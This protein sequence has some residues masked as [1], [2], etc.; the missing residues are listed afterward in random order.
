ME[1]DH[2]N[3]VIAPGNNMITAPGT[4]K[5][6]QQVELVPYTKMT[7]FQFVPELSVKRADTHGAHPKMGIYRMQS[8]PRGIFFFV[9][10]I[11]FDKKPRH[12]ADMDRENLVTL[13]RELGFTNYYYEDLT[14][15]QCI[16]LLKQLIA[17][18]D[19]TQ[20]DS[21]VCCIQTHGDLVENKTQMEFVDGAFASTEEITEMFSNNRCPSL[22]GK[23]KLFFFPFCRGKF[24]DNGTTIDVDGGNQ[25][26]PLLGPRKVPTLCDVL[27]CYGTMPGYKAHRITDSGTWYV[28]GICKIFAEHAC[29]THV[30]NLLKKVSEYIIK[31][32]DSG[33]MQVASFENLGFN[34]LLYFNP[35]QAPVAPITTD[36]LTSG[37]SITM[38]SRCSGSW[39]SEPARN[40]SRGFIGVWSR[41]ARGFLGLF[42]RL[43][44][45]ARVNIPLI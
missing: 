37:S 7:S 33:P 11:K 38:G 1:G 18:N 43:R 17:S 29:D 6:G 4:S 3:V 34:Q 19:L 41:L 35:E 27:V 26:P 9:N 2:S 16:H 23:P 20:V 14:K 31:F 22:V 36:T 44:P 15:L 10:I 40:L 28:Q 21:F 32:Y 25:A 30:E 42:P 39:C 24:V 8:K 12:G 5:S 45:E 13:F